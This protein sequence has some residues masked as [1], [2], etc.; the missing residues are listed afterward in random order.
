VHTVLILC[1]MAYVKSLEKAKFPP[2]GAEGSPG[3][4]IKKL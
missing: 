1:C 2:L 3:I 4:F